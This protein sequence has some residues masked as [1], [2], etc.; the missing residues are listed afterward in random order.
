[1]YLLSI[2]STCRSILLYLRFRLYFWKNVSRN[3]GNKLVSQKRN[4][5]R[6][7][8]CYGHQFV[9]VSSNPWWVVLY[10]AD[11]S[12]SDRPLV[13]TPRIRVVYVCIY[14]IFTNTIKS[15]VYFVCS[16]YSRISRTTKSFL[17]I[18]LLMERFF[19]F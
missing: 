3:K 12:F 13:R 19:R 16:L 17:I 7:L 8:W 5:R 1:M 6:M 14:I 10:R 18:L 15:K 9:E 4:V 2:V 11:R